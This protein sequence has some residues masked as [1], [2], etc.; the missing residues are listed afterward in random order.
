VNI[1]D[2]NIYG[3]SKMGSMA[4]KDMDIIIDRLFKEIKELK[5]E[6][7]K[8]KKEKREHVEHVE[9]VDVTK[10]DP[11]ILADFLSV[12][13]SP[14]RISIMILLYQRDRYFSE[15]ESILTIGPS[16]LRHHL[17]KLIKFDLISQERARGKYSIT[18]RGKSIIT[19][20]SEIY[21][22]FIMG[23]KYG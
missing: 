5:E 7:N 13:S 3:L 12:F 16:S 15:L 22:K 20:L 9:Y 14:E 18:E 1:S 11:D 17:S 6:V 2:L 8:L 21:S 4:E 23:E 19:F 10:I